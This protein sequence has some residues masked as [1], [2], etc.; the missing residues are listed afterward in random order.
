MAKESAAA[1]LNGSESST[2]NDQGGE[3]DSDGEPF[4]APGDDEATVP[5][6]SLE[7]AGG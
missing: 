5:E 7:P 1:R 2:G 6:V 3:D 4:E